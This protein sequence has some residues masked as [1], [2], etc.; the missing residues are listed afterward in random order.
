MQTAK[1][2][3]GFFIVEILV[4]LVIIGILVTA[5]MPNLTLYTQRAQYIDNVT[6]A[7]SVKASVEGCLLQNYSTFANC[8]AGSTGIPADVASNYGGFVNA[9]AVANGV[10]TIT[11]TSKFGTN[12]LGS[13]TYI[14]TP[15]TTTGGGIT[16]A[17]TGTCA[18]AGLC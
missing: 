15:L 1:K 17:A 14:L 18:A 7:D 8:D 13:Y 9:V 3:A 6:T 2:T 16:W 10:I 11:S 4:V 5:L 12:G